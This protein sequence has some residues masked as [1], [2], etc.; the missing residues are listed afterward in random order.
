VE[1]KAWRSTGGDQRPAGV[2]QTSGNDGAVAVP[3][4]PDQTPDFDR[5]WT[6]RSLETNVI[7]DD[8]MRIFFGVA[9]VLLGCVIAFI[10]LF[11]TLWDSSCEGIDCATAPSSVFLAVGALLVSAPIVAGVRRSRPEWTW[12]PVL[13]AGGGAVAL[14]AATHGSTLESSARGTDG[15]AV[16]INPATGRVGHA[17]LGGSLASLDSVLGAGRRQH[18]ADDT[19]REWIHLG[20]PGTYRYPSGCGRANKH[21]VVEIHY[22]GA[23]VSE[24]GGHTFLIVITSRGSQTTA[25]AA[26]GEKL[27]HAASRHPGLACDT[28]IGDTTDPG[29]PV[30]RYCT[31]PIGDGRYLWLGQDPVSS[32]ALA[33]IPL[34]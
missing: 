7:I 9:S 15:R 28:S 21:S 27:D 30:Y 24:C 34:Q 14:I 31:G 29:V 2:A 1:I 8:W 13:L 18:G 20:A 11:A 3:S 19:S 17:R 32:I 33:T 23:E 12:L 5:R 16:V 22:V 26:I 10:G 6:S 25:G 4:R